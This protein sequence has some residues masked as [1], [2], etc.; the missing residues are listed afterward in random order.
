MAK[1]S[2]TVNDSFVS[3]VNVYLTT[4]NGGNQNASADDI[5]KEALAVYRWYAQQVF[6]GRAVVA[7]N[8]NMDANCQVATPMIPAKDPSI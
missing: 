3:E 2:L 4:I 6:E 7:V 1:V 8:R 5:A